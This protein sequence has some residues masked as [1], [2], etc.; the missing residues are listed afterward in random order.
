M[1]GETRLM[2]LMGISVVAGVLL[3]AMLIRRG[4]VRAYGA[5]LAG[6]VLAAL[7]FYLAAQQARDM[8]GL[9]HMIMLA[10]FVLPAM[11]GMVLGGGVMWWRRRRA[12]K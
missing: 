8:Q 11:L 5:F 4:W 7:G 9:G 12:Q 3:G 10:V 1:G 2:L 6:H